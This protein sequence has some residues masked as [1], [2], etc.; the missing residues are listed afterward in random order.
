MKPNFLFIGPSKSGSSWLHWVLAQHTQVYV[1]TVKDLYFFDRFH[2]RGEAWYL[3]HFSK[4]EPHHVAIGEF[5]H[6]YLYSAE[7]AWRIK[8]VL[9]DVKLLTMLRDPVTRSFSHYLFLKRSGLTKLPFWEAVEQHPK[10]LTDSF[11]GYH[12]SLYRDLFPDSQL[13]LF[14]FND[15]KQSSRALASGVCDF[16]GIESPDFDTDEKVLSA[17]KPRNHY[18]SRAI[19]LGADTA[20]MVGLE[21]LVG[22]VKSSK[23]AM[24]LLFTEYTEAERPLPSKEDTERLKEIFVAD[25]K[26][27]ITMFP[28]HRWISKLYK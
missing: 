11:Y 19:K 28:E 20:R 24:T 12:L 16:L 13:S 5:S 1:P 4:S 6:E 22:S 14:N 15:L 25:G 18:L 26:R 2:T 9:P 10:I 27:L 3:N 17:A 7:A 8:S 21:T 23:K